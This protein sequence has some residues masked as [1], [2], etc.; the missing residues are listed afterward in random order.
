MRKPK[1]QKTKTEA[2]K[3]NCRGHSQS[4]Q[5]YDAGQPETPSAGLKFTAERSQS[6]IEAAAAGE[7][8]HLLYREAAENDPQEQSMMQEA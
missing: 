2:V 6:H 4:N 7:T 3:R 1:G 5:E 8:K